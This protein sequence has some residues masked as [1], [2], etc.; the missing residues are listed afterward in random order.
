MVEK[1]VM[2][3]Q[4]DAVSG[5]D[6]E[7]LV[8]SAVMEASEAQPEPLSAMEVEAIVAAAIAAIPTPEPV[9]IPTP[10]MMM[11]GPSGEPIKI[12]SVLD[13]TGDLGAYGKPMRNSVDIA[14]E[15][16]NDAGGILGRPVRAVHKDGGTSAQVATD[17]AN[18]LVKTDGVHVI[19][20]TFG[21]R[22]HN[23]SRPSG[24]YPQRNSADFTVRNFPRSF[25]P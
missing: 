5:E 25:D 6:I 18:A 20:G 7:K 1:A 15:L 14:A 8:S 21:Q 24:H 9:V 17:A 2:M 12:G 19:V 16:I 13:F 22:V 3:A 10:A 4:E 23:R 11:S